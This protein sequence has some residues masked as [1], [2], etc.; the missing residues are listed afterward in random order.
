[1]RNNGE[2]N[3]VTYLV[4]ALVAAGIFYAYHVGPLYYDNLA[5][6]DI[7]GEAFSV[8]IL[9]GEKAA[10]DGMLI[11]ANSRSPDTSHYEVDKDG[12]E[13]VRPGYGLTEDNVTFTFDEATRK[14]TV[15]IEYDRIVEFKPLKKRKSYHLVAEKTGIVAK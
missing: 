3:P 13:Q 6:R 14:L 12:V 9:K 15:R 2:T 11:R 1:M 8:Y 4:L 7:A 10:L 5:A